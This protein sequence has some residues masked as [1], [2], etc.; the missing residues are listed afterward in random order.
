MESILKVLR[1]HVFLKQ[2]IEENILL[3][4]KFFVLQNKTFYTFT[5]Y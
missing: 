3:A 1:L 2:R 5:I 4:Q